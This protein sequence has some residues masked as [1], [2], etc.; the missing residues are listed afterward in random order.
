VNFTLN[1]IKMRLKFPHPFL[2]IA[3]LLGGFSTFLAYEKKYEP[4]A[5][6]AGVAVA[7]A[8]AAQ[9]NKRED[10]EDSEKMK[11]WYEERYKELQEDTRRR[12]E[13]FMWDKG[14]LMQLIER[15]ENA[16][17]RDQEYIQEL[18]GLRR[19]VGIL[20]HQLEQQAKMEGLELEIER[21]RQI[22]T[23]QPKTALLPESKLNPIE[24]E[25]VM[26]KEQ[27]I[28]PSKNYEENP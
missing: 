15:E 3:I 20:N 5:A 4:S 28:E 10:S 21:L 2:T 18:E 19:D 8:V 16:R 26:P 11:S 25:I 24:M 12:E 7:A 14:K 27:V 22:L 1:Q 17:Q 13:V 23:E 9:S 6:M